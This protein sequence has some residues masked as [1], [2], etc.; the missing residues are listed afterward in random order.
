MNIELLRKVQDKLRELG[1]SRKT[2]QLF[3]MSDFARQKTCGTARCIGGWT[4]E[5]GNQPSLWGGVE[6]RLPV[7]LDV[8]AVQVERLC[9]PNWWPKKFMGRRDPWKPSIAQAIARID[10]FIATDGAE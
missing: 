1:K 8:S 10:H 5:L 2:R 9:Y 6:R 3:D 4:A 7:L